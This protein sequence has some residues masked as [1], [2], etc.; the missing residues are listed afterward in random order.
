MLIMVM[1][2][3]HH[4]VAIFKA[5]VGTPIVLDL[6]VTM[7]VR[8]VSASLVLARNSSPA[9]AMFQDKVATQALKPTSA[10]V[11][12][13]VQDKVATLVQVMVQDE[14]TLVLDPIS[15][16]APTMAR[17]KEGTLALVLTKAEGTGSGI[18]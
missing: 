9:R 18:A 2:L 8:E 5:G 6:E 11:Q 3:M 13:V 12:A 16:I 17:G 4:K 1:H 7:V 10:A 15:G 14:A